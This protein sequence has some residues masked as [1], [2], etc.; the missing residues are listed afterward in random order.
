MDRPPTLLVHVLGRIG[1]S[2]RRHV[3]LG[4]CH[5]PLRLESEQV[6]KQT[7]ERCKVVKLHVESW[8]KVDL[9]QP[10]NPS[11]EICSR[12]KRKTGLGRGQEERKK[13]KEKRKRTSVHLPSK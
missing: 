5:R 13:E 10:L 1:S 6:A 3:V 7:R 2:Q 4:Q 12:R 9:R 8:V 11:R